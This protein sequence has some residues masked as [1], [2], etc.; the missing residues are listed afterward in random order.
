VGVIGLFLRGFLLTRTELPFVSEGCASNGGAPPLPSATNQT[1]TTST[2]TP[3]ARFDKAVIV[4]VDALRYDFVCPDPRQRPHANTRRL[5]RTLAALGLDGGDEGDE[6]DLNSSP[7]RPSAALRFVADTPTITMSRL[8]GLLTGG[9]P[10][11]LDVGSSFGGGGARVTEDSLAGQLQRKGYR[12]AFMG[13]DTWMQ[14]LP[15]A[16]NDSAGVGGVGAEGGD[17]AGANA[18]GP[19]ATSW[20]A[21]PYPSFNVK[22]LHTV[23]EGVEAH[24]R[25]YLEAG[26]QGG[27]GENG[28]FLPSAAAANAT[29]DDN[30]TPGQKPVPAWDVLIAHYL[31]VDHAGHTHG[32][33]SPQMGAKLDQMDV[34]L[35][36][37]VEA[38]V[39]GAKGSGGVGGGGEGD[40]DDNKEGPYANTLLLVFGDHGQTLA[41]DHGGGAPAE[42]DS[43]LLVADVGRLRAWRDARRARRR[44]QG[45]RRGRRR[46]AAAAASTSP[47]NAAMFDETHR[48]WSP[49]ALREL[50]RAAAAAA[51]ERAWRLGGGGGGEEEE[52][53]P[54]QAPPP[55]VDLACTGSV[56]QVDFTPTVSLLLGL[57]I[58][59]G[60]I[61]KVP[62]ELWA[63]L[64]PG[65][66]RGGGGEDGG[67]GALAPETTTPTTT[68]SGWLRSYASALAANAAQARAYLD[69]YARAASLPHGELRRCR[70]LF[71][72]SEA[73]EAAAAAADNNQQQQQDR[74]IAA[75]A[76]RSRFLD[77]SAALFRAQFTQFGVGWIL[78]GCAAA[79]AALLLQLRLLAGTTGGAAGTAGT[80]SLLSPSSSSSSSASS[81]LTT[82]LL[83][84]L[85]HTLESRAALA[86][87]ALHA[88]ALFSVGALMGE[89]RLV[90]GLQ[91]LLSCALGF[92]AWVQCGKA[93]EVFSGG[94]AIRQDRGS[95]GAAAAETTTPPRRPRTRA[96]TAAANG[97]PAQTKPTPPSSSSPSASSWWPTPY[98]QL[99]SL[100]LTFLLLASA[101][102]LRRS[103]L[104]DRWGQDPHDKSCPTDEILGPQDPSNRLPELATTHGPLMLCAL[105]WRV[106]DRLLGRALRG[107]GKAPRARRQ[108]RGPPKTIF[109]RAL[110]RLAR[111]AAAAEYG[112]V[113]AWW[114]VR[115]LGVAEQPLSGAWADVG[116]LVAAYGAA[117]EEEGEGGGFG[118]TLAIAGDTWLANP[119]ASAAISS[120]VR[121]FKRVRSVL[122]ASGLSGGLSVAPPLSARRLVASSAPWLRPLLAAA[123]SDLPLRLLLPRVCYFLALGVLA[124]YALFALGMLGVQGLRLAAGAKAASSSS[125]SAAAADDNDDPQHQV[126]EGARALLWLLA[127]LTGPLVLVLG[128]RGPATVLL[129]LVQGVASLALLSLLAAA[130]RRGE[131]GG[132]GGA[133]SRRIVA[134][135]QAEGEEAAP[136]SS[137]STTT[138][139]TASTAVVSGAGATAWAL[140][141]AQLFFCSAHFCEFSG[142]Q[143]ASAFIGY[144]DMH[145]LV[146]GTLLALNTFGLSLLTHASLPLL[147]VVAAAAGGEGEG[148]VSRR[149]VGG[150]LGRAALVGGAYRGALLGA[151]VLSAAIQL[152]HILLWAIFAPKLVFE[153]GATGLADAARLL[154]AALAWALL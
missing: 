51:N 39:A 87:A 91:A 86:A 71:E 41:G 27:G 23:D 98:P 113:S 121:V 147:A 100:L 10:T 16:F 153:V 107:G 48:A 114:G 117:A 82:R 126:E 79:V 38:L 69:S 36:E 96:S 146:S 55:S 105:L 67:N 135:H 125:S 58:P 4:I 77:A 85:P 137:S 19:P 44:R 88:G 66:K 95:K 42:T 2:C 60:S 92:S 78:G 133:H 140:A 11:F 129:A 34:A 45:Q 76:A 61:G 145:P 22:D 31:G 84:L 32:V 14:L 15:H 101:E 106:A 143:Y 5:P 59:Y 93:R 149:A 65:P 138:T 74:L 80:A 49:Y 118:G 120:S 99:L 68:E 97:A 130:R 151:S 21:H 104:V 102:G 124:A 128:Y 35:A 24:L 28:V 139:T 52:A 62:A 57:P 115:L 33:V 110:R 136:A 47:P 90:V 7:L 20:R 112:C 142:L 53:M 9:L 134:K 8:K 1:T 103:G 152:R 12:L 94:T 54:P 123:W 43:A 132:G 63:V 148:G 3:H 29:A 50:A 154:A 64:A 144:D 122:Q 13:D 37:T 108:R 18:A 30:P 40:D 119:A 72:E 150:A 6:D 17:A 70:A 116:R 56:P 25:P 81:S 89:G 111:L 131:V 26:P 75:I 83:A 109:V 127:A 46:A 73:A 141:S